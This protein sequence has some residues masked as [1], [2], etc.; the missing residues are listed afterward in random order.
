MTDIKTLRSQQACTNKLEKLQSE[1]ITGN[2]GRL[3]WEGISTFRN[4]IYYEKNRRISKSIRKSLAAISITTQNHSK[5]FLATQRNYKTLVNGIC[6]FIQHSN[7]SM[8]K[9]GVCFVRIN[10]NHLN[11]LLYCMGNDRELRK[12]YWFEPHGYDIQSEN[13]KARESMPW[14]HEGFETQMQLVAEEVNR[15]LKINVSFILPRQFMPPHWGQTITHDKYCGLHNFA[16]ALH[17]SSPES[18]VKDNLKSFKE[19]DIC[20]SLHFL[21]DKM[22]NK[23]CKIKRK[24]KEDKLV[25]RKQKRQR[26]RDDSAQGSHKRVRKPRK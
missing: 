9:Y 17:P 5:C 1:Y 14:K 3:F 16:F 25:E 18:F 12:L 10:T 7:E 21:K 20:S 8:C 22:L 24:Q 2:C 15:N 26:Q 4:W 6:A 11:T 19:N 23:L 13:N